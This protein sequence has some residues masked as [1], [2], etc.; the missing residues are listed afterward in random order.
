M[1]FLRKMKLSFK[2]KRTDILHARPLFIRY[3]TAIG[4]QPSAAQLFR[5]CQLVIIVDAGLEHAL[6]HAAKRAAP[7][8]RQILKSSTGSDA[9]LRI[10][11][12]RIIG[13]AAGIAKIFLHSEFSPFLKLK[14][15]RQSVCH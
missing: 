14:L 5:F 9:M 6:I 2:R 12:F 15:K 1:N 8:I 4:L 11:F 7:V 13:I 10:T 3:G